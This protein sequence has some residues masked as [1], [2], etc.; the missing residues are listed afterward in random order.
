MLIIVVGSAVIAFFAL[1]VQW[2]NLAASKTVRKSV[3]DGVAA[4][5]ALENRIEKS[6]QA[7]GSFELRLQRLDDAITTFE[8]RN[9]GE[10]TNT[11]ADARTAP[12]SKWVRSRL[13]QGRIHYACQH[14]FSSDKLEPAARDW[15][16][17]FENV[18]F[19]HML[20]DLKPRVNLGRIPETDCLSCLEREV[21]ADSARFPLDWMSET[22]P[23]FIV[24][25][26]ETR[27]K[28][29]VLEA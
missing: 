15:L 6:I 14:T 4:L 25:G 5:N 27:T 2:S 23:A 29:R 17:S 7:Q 26:F 11:P 10:S 8:K 3:T 21:G 28:K 12:V 1:F 13:A 19:M 20:E 18:L 24:Q 9:S 22:N 16:V